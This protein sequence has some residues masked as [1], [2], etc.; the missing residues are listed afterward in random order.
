MTTERTLSNMVVRPSGWRFR[1]EWA[2][3]AISFIMCAVIALFVAV[4]IATALKDPEHAGTFT[5]ANITALFTTPLVIKAL[6]NTAEMTLISV[7]V[8]LAF[9]MPMAWLVERTNLPGRA[10]VFPMLML[11]LLVPGIFTAMG[12]LYL[13]HPRIGMLAGIL[14]YLGSPNIL[15]V[16]GMGVITGINLS[17]LVFIML[18]ASFRAVDASL[19]ESAEIHGVGL[20]WRLRTITL[21]L[22]LPSILGAV[23]YIAMIAMATFDVPAVIGMS[24]QIYTFSTLIY[25]YVYPQMGL[26]NFGIIAATGC[27]MI[28]VGLIFSWFYLRVIQQSH[29]YMVVKG[30]NYRAKT[31]ELSLGLKV[32]GWG[33]IGVNIGA[34]LILPLLILGWI[35]LL[36]YVQP[37]SLDALQSMSFDSFRGI[38]YAFWLS[39]K[40]TAILTFSVTTILV[41]VGLIMSW[42]VT[43][44]DSVVVT[45]TV[46]TIAFLPHAIP[47]VIFAVAA[48]ILAFF[49]LPEWVP[50]YGTIGILIVVYVITK[51]SFP[52]RMF[53]NGMLQIHRELDEAASV[54]GLGAFK[55]LRWI[56]IPLLMPAIIY[57]W[58][59][60]ALLTYREFTLAAF[61]V[62]RENQTMTTNIF[63][64]I[65]RQPN[66]S[67]AMAIVAL[68]VMVPLVAIYFA[69]GRKRLGSINL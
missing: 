47:N 43:R 18:S 14:P 19:E 45:K 37:F 2:L 54:F 15:S 35:S 39:T 46:D 41:A 32:F 7:A 8:S 42:V 53:N 55:R 30:K 60:M 24:A 50:F 26:P 13:A 44:S 51:L 9:G 63:S 67:A 34:S 21:P 12:W 6:L 48:M 68:G 22:L 33:L 59:F 66:S 1:A 20:F 38:P 16:W 52:T 61:L 62:T 11:T 25:A 64:Q 4:I 36:P 65:L 27:V 23:I 40:N 49:W 3:I 10:L 57:T 17:S 69:L 28:V 31:Y 56:L 58:I 5:F 29:K